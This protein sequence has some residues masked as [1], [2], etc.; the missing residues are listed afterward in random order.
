MD[1]DEQEAQRRKNQVGMAPHGTRGYF[2][3]AKYV[4]SAY[5]DPNAETR[6]KLQWLK[7]NGY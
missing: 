7:E 3:K 2:E 1:P 6:A 5:K 4:L